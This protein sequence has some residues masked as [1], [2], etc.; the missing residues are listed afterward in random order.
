MSWYNM[1]AMS[2]MPAYVVC[3]IDVERRMV[4]SQSHLHG[5]CSLDRFGLLRWHRRG[6]L[7]NLTVEVIVVEEGLISP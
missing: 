2:A 5:W 4:S 3:L 6:T 7:W 1:A